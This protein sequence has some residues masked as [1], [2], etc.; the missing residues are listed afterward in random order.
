[1]L[2]TSF[3]TLFITASPVQADSDGISKAIMSAVQ[4]GV[5]SNSCQAKLTN[6]AGV[7][8]NTKL[9]Y[10]PS[11]GDRNYVL[12]HKGTLY[13]A[14]IYRM[15]EGD[16]VPSA[17]ACRLR[18]YRK[19]G[20]QWKLYFEQIHRS[21]KMVNQTEIDEENNTYD[22]VVLNKHGDRL[23]FSYANK[24]RTLKSIHFK[25]KSKSRVQI[26]E[27]TK[28]DIKAFYEGTLGTSTDDSGKVKKIRIKK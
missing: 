16:G 22:R 24:P 10:A 18:Q 2:V 17:M 26:S 8:K 15:V 23:F 11:G 14:S 27:F 13:E 3:I 28:A 21:D 7:P 25:A 4:A 20:D 19:K 1:M 12:E 9:R 6:R 5:F